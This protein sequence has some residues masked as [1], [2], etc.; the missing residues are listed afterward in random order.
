SFNNDGRLDIAINGPDEGV[1]LLYFGDGK[2]NFPG[3]PEE[4]EDLLQPFG[5]DAA[6]LNGDGN[7]DMAMGGITRVPGAS[8]V[9][10][11]L[12]DGTGAFRVSEVSV[13]DLPASNMFGDLN[14]DGV[15]DLV[16]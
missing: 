1:C 12:G 3:P 7:L 11:L 6:D 8:V 16:V 9:T 4:I 10:I 2:G 5:M 15:P 14:N 13:G